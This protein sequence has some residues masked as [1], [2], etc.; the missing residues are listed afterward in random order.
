MSEQTAQEAID[1]IL[2]RKVSAIAKQ[3]LK[4][5]LKYHIIYPDGVQ[6]I[7]QEDHD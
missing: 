6:N 5:I 1:K 3:K 2:E 7:N 4:E